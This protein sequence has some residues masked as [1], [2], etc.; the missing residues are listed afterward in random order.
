MPF[1]V[2][3][4]RCDGVNPRGANCA[5]GHTQWGWPYGAPSSTRGKVRERQTTA[6]RVENA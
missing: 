1:T 6:D 4:N 2:S 3:S 5:K